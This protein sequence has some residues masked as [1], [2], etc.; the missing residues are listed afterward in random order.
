MDAFGYH[1][2]GFAYPPETD[3]NS[4][5]NGFAFRGAEIMHD[6]LAAHGAGQ[7]IW[8]TEWGWLIDPA[9]YGFGYCTSDPRWSGRQWQI[10]S[11]QQ[12]ADYL[13]RAYQWADTNWP[14]MGPMMMFNLDFAETRDLCDPMSWYAIRD[15]SGAPRPAYT[16]LAQMPKNSAYRPI[17][18]VV[19]SSLT[20]L[21]AVGEPGPH[22]QTV[23]ITNAGGGTFTWTATANAGQI[24]PV[25]DPTSGQPG[26][27]LSVTVDSSGRPV[28]TYRGSFII[29]APG[30]QGSP[31]TVPITLHVVPQVRRVYL[32]AVRR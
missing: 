11:P 24:V 4:V 21:V 19:P 31:V 25:L 13:V 9:A 6:I 18:A 28:G 20:F 12:Q 22:T 30:A 2:Y 15:R 16:A 14:W 29:T 7:P 23:M 32:P 27:P 10:V 26:Q 17:L 8:A 1:P 3:P 5:P